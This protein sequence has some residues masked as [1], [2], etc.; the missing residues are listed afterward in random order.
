M[1][2]YLLLTDI[3]KDDDPDHHSPGAFTQT[4]KTSDQAIE[5]YNTWLTKQTDIDMNHATVE[6][7][8]FEKEIKLFS[9][10]PWSDFVYVIVFKTNFNVRE[11]SP[12]NPVHSL[13]CSKI[14]PTKTMAMTLLGDITYHSKY[15]IDECIDTVIEKYDTSAV[16]S[17]STRTKK[18]WCKI[19]PI[20]VANIDQIGYT[21]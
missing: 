16:L 8:C 18:C 4:Y 1:K 20:R 12:L 14:I 6:Y 13:F 10:I 11:G 7:A 15:R 9:D 2:V 17:D 3:V 21:E 19:V 5:Q